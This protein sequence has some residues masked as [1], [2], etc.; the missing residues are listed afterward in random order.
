MSM[1]AARVKIIPAEAL[2]VASLRDRLRPADIAEMEAVGL[3]PGQGLWKSYRLSV[4]AK[5]ALVDG[6]VAA[7]FGMS[8]SPLAMRGEPWLLTSPLVEKVKVSFVREGRN[9]VAEMLAV[10]P[11][12]SGYVDASYIKAVRLLKALGFWV[13]TPLPFGVKGALFSKYGI[14][15]PWA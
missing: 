9:A 10:C 14:E 8:G 12:L 2:H 13:D 5:T 6:E 11:V 4:L 7:M 15:R 1:M 3:R